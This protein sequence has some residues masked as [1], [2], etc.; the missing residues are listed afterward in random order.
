MRLTMMASAAVSA[1]RYPALP[2]LDP[3]Q[4]G[5]TDDAV[6]AV[7]AAT[8]FIPLHVQ[9]AAVAAM[10][11]APDLVID[12]GQLIDTTMLTIDGSTSGYFVRHGSY[13]VLFVNELMVRSSVTVLGSTPLIIVA[14]GRAVIAANIRLNAHGLASGPGTALGG[15]G[16]GNAG[17]TTVQAQRVS[18]GGGGGSHGSR[19]GPG[20]TFD[21][22][23][24]PAGSGGATYGARPDDPLIGGSSGGNGGFAFAPAGLGGGGGGAVQISSA[25]SVE[26]SATIDAGGGGGRGGS[27]ELSGGGGGGAGGEILVEAPMITMTGTATLTANGGGGG[28]GGGGAN[29][30][31]LAANGQ[32]AIPA[33]QTAAGGTGGVP[34]GSAGGQGAATTSSGFVDGQAG[35]DNNSSGGGGGGGAGR[36]WL[37]YRATTPPVMNGAN[38]SPPAG[39]DPELP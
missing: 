32:D 35:G 31:T 15:G 21:P 7:D 9:P 3:K 23:T 39:L 33:P 22:P 38:I 2:A 18:S 16:V 27:T 26:V 12:H 17:S 36:I 6:V 5:G 11:D 4:D 29:G 24:I 37:R 19:G 14:R 1:C 10:A 30:S 28:G 20:G 8:S 25:V 34:Q 13:A